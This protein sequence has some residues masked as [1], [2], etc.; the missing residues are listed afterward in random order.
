MPCYQSTNLPGGVTTTGRTSYTTEADCLNACREGACC[1]GTTCT[2]KPQC[3]CQGAGKVFKGVGTTCDGNPC[4]CCCINGNA[5]A[6]KNEQQ[7]T[8]AGGTWK[9]YSCNSPAPSSIPLTLSLNNYSAFLARSPTS[10]APGTWDFDFSCIKT[11]YSLTNVIPPYTWGKLAAEASVSLLVSTSGS[12]GP[13]GTSSTCGCAIPLFYGGEIFSP[14]EKI[15]RRSGTT[16]PLN[17]TPASVGA[18]NSWGLVF[19]AAG[20]G[21][22]DLPQ[23]VEVPGFCSGQYSVSGVV[24]GPGGVQCGTYTLGNP[25]P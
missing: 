14:E 2:V 22:N 12:F 17:C 1:E 5:D 25:L 20:Q 11:S 21:Y 18:G 10:T 19:L 7:C 9:S 6:T 15:S 13:G 16:T 3:Q 23:A 8:A 24:W 4:G